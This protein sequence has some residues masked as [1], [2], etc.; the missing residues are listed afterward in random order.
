MMTE[1]HMINGEKIILDISWDEFGRRDLYDF[2]G[3]DDYTVVKAANG[4]K[5]AINGKWIVAVFPY[6]KD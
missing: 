4:K 5:V 3:L 1:V 6:E 2:D